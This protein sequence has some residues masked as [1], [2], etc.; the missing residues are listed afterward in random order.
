M[1]IYGNIIT[2]LSYKLISVIFVPES[3]SIVMNSREKL[4]KALS[5]Q[6]GSLPIDFGGTGVTGMHISIVRGL[7]EHF[8]LEN[9][10]VRVAEPYQ[11]LGLIDDDLKDVLKIDTASVAAPNTLFGFPL[12]N[13]KG[14]KTPWGQD[15]LVPGKFEVDENDAGVFI[16]PQGDRTAQPSGHMPATGFFFD[17]IIRQP[18]IQEDR[19]NP[20]DNL[21]EFGLISK[22]NINYYKRQVDIAGK[23]GRGIVAAVSGTAFG[24]I[25]L[26]PAPFLKEPKG[27]RDIAEW[28]MS[29]AIRQDYIHSIF[30]RQLEYAIENLKRVYRAV[31]DKIDVLFLCGTD[32]GTQTGTFCSVDTYRSLWKPY[33]SKLNG[34]I[35]ENTNWKT[36]KHSCGAV[37]DFIEEFIDSGFD[38]INPVQCSA[39]GMD[40]AKLKKT[41]GDRIVFWGGGVDTQNTLPFGTPQEVYE[42]VRKRIDIFSE[43]GGFVFN[44]I[45]NIQANT[46]IKN[47]VAMFEAVWRFNS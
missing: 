27:I 12:N 34:W 14:W 30:S 8:G 9:R 4:Q 31:G 11:M 36:F 5:H 38:I 22:D 10:P 26:V 16:Y 32:F 43:N 42:Q 19:L 18:P 29:T 35:H 1:F 7:R 3:I 21:E 2:V 20:D 15:V 46:P 33:Y 13:W 23:S 41:Y 45:H 25:A 24:D 28:Y 47:V 44:S 17:T 40:A 39:K 6:P 37:F